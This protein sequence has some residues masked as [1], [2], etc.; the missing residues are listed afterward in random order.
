MK[1][2]FQPDYP[3]KEFYTIV[4]IF[5]HLGYFATLDP[6]DSFDFAFAWRDSTWVQPSPTLEAIGAAKPVLNLR[7]LDISKRLVE[8]RFREVFGYSSFV[9]PLRFRGPCV[10][11]HNENAIGGSIVECPISSPDPA[12]VHQRWIDARQGDRIL[13]YRLPVVMGLIPM[14]Y[15]QQKEI[16]RE[17]IKTAT[18]AVHIAETRDMLAPEEIRQI[19]EFC[20]AL[21]LDFGELDL[22]RAKEDGA[23]YILDANKTPG[24]LGMCNRMNWEAQER[25]GAIERL[26]DAF[27]FGIGERLRR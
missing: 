21:G 11:K 22:L 18:R 19:L 10:A 25:R 3:D 27:D 16:P 23:I 1:V 20:D 8:T 15:V 13:E 4:P 9:D 24:G 2:L 12:L 6:T 17:R 14:V 5:G 7:C 26:A